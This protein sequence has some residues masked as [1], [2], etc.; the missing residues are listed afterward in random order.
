[1][2]H[3]RLFRNPARYPVR[4][5]P[6][7]GRPQVPPKLQEANLFFGN[8]DYE[9]ATILYKELFQEAVN[10][11]IPF[12]P[13]FSVQSAFAWIKAGK[14]EKGFAAFKNGF[15]IWITQKQWKGLRRASQI[16]FSRLKDEG[17]REES[18]QLKT[19]LDGQ[20]P[21]SIKISPVWQDQEISIGFPGKSKLPVVCPQCVR[22]TCKSQGSGMV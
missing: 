22:C 21:D 20:I 17:F 15:Q 2:M 19:W 10:R 6:A 12:A 1:M 8:G 4:P 7:V 13:R 3:R 18:L 14:I 16:S 11:Q 5:I 9:N